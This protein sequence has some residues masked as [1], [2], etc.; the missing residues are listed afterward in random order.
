MSI[1]RTRE[2]VALVLALLLAG[3]LAGCGPGPRQTTVVSNGQASSDATDTL[4]PLQRGEVR[5]E[6]LEVARR[7]LDAWRDN[8]LEVMRELYADQQYEHFA[9]LDE[10]YRAE[11][12][13]R[14]RDHETLFFD[15]IELN[16]TGTEASVNYRFKDNSY[17]TSTDGTRLTQPA[18]DEAEMRFGLVQFEGKWIII[19][20]IA[21]PERLQ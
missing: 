8:D 3:S 19:R 21:G 10:T 11:G 2:V 5:R 7:A 12:K 13:T 1:A 20:L 15:V 9:S 4:T 17:F 14:V 6:V 18:G 16:S